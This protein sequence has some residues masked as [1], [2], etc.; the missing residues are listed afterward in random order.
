MR[1]FMPIP[2]IAGRI[3]P[4]QA[5]ARKEANDVRSCPCACARLWRVATFDR[6]I[7]VG[8]SSTTTTATADLH[9]PVAA[10]ARG[11]RRGNG[12]AAA[13]HHVRAVMWRLHPHA[14]RTF[15]G[16]TPD[17][18]VLGRGARRPATPH[19]ARMI[20]A[21]AASHIVGVLLSECVECSTICMAQSGTRDADQQYEPQADDMECH[22]TKPVFQ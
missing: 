6:K 17:R 13:E 2:R 7:A 22:D 15:L 18:N 1:R 21:V 11:Y 9:Y 12:L 19:E 16:L 3:L 4:S 20:E 8:A 14:P 10:A 5:S